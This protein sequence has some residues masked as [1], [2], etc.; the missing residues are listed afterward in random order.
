MDINDL[1]N[2]EKTHT[3][4]LVHPSTDEPLGIKVEV[5]SIDSAAAER[6]LLDHTDKQIEKFAKGKR[7]T[8][9]QSK[10]AEIER[11]AS[12]VVSWDW[13]EHTFEGDK[14]AV[15]VATAVR[16]FLKMPW[17]E[18]QVREAVEN[19]RNFTTT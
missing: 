5:R 14:P 19:V 6:V 11:L 18:R 10:K 3:V 16:V 17:A 15:S 9:A 2:Y 1:V 4:E 13:G 7:P 8:A 12:C